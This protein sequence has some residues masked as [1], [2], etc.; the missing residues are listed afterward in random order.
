MQ[1]ESETFELSKG[2]KE[3]RQFEPFL[4]VSL[5]QKVWTVTT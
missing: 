1:I 3:F 2:Q 4:V 5:F